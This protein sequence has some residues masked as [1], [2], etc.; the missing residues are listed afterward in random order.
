M[1]Y[2]LDT[3]T[4]IYFLKGTHPSV[5][6]KLSACAPSDIRIPAIVMAELL[7]GAEKSQRVRENTEK[8]LAFLFPF[9]IVPFG[10]AEARAY[11]KIR[12][13]LEK[14]G[15]P[16]GPNDTI[17]AATVLANAGALVTNNLAEFRR[18]RK[19]KV[20]NWAKP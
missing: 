4:C 15:Q 17:I 2:F 8:V 3:N 1:S 6:Q 9:E 10:V 11:A 16:I 5:K 20:E 7:F 14:A 18:V 13:S 19:L 12:C